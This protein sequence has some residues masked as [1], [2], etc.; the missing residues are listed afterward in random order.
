MQLEDIENLGMTPYA[1]LH[2]AKPE[3]KRP[4]VLEV[5]NAVRDDL[6]PE[7]SVGQEAKEAEDT[8]VGRTDERTA[9]VVVTPPDDRV[10]QRTPS[11]PGAKVS[12]QGGLPPE[13]RL[14]SA[15]PLP[16]GA[17]AAAVAKIDRKLSRAKLGHDLS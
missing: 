3:P 10:R 8:G 2:G 16:H 17:T 7:E 14:R 13:I 4:S 5:L 9:L 11:P 15:S 6:V 1:T 12:I